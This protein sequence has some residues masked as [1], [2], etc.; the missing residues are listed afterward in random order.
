MKQPVPGVIPT[1]ALS[2]K[3]TP[4]RAAYLN[5]GEE[6]RKETQDDTIK[7]D[8]NQCIHPEDPI[9]RANSIFHTTLKAMRGD[10]S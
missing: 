8:F 6:S 4:K 1:R 9:N 10:Y 5:H 3:M 2:K 7:Y